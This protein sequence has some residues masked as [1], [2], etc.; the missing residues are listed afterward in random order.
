MHIALLGDSIFDNQSYVL[1]GEPDVRTQLAALLSEDDR[2]TLQ[3]GDGGVLQE[4]GEQL[5]TLPDDVTHLVISAGGNDL[6]LQIG[7]LDKSAAS[8]FEVLGLLATVSSDFHQSYR[9]M[10][11]QAQAYNLPVAV[12]T[13]YNPLFPEP[14][15]QVITTTALRMFNDCIIQAAVRAGIPVIELRHVCTTAQDFANPIEPSAVGGEKIA[16]VIKRVVCEHD[17]SNRSSQIYIE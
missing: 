6:L 5:K 7:L 15:F 11:K 12:C 4:V 16:R 9:A 14:D 2:V 17:F 1:P 3:A 10:L 13:V 8:V